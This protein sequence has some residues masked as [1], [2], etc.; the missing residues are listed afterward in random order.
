MAAHSL[1]PHYFL[2]GIIMPNDLFSTEAFEI[3]APVLD[4]V[5]NPQ[6]RGVTTDKGAGVIGV[7]HAKK[8]LGLLGGSDRVFR[9]SA[10]VYGESGQQGVFGHSTDSAGT[11]VYGNSVGS[12]WGVRG[13]STDGI[14]VQGQSFGNGLAGKF[15]GD[16]E[17]TGNLILQGLDLQSLI[18]QLRLVGNFAEQIQSLER[19]LQAL[20][21]E[22]QRLKQDI[23]AL[24]QSSSG[25]ANQLPAGS[26][27]PRISVAKS[28]GAFSIS[29]QGF[30]ANK[31]IS[32]RVVDDALA[33]RT[34]TQSSD[35]NGRFTLSQQIPCNAGLVLHFSA[36]DGR[37]NN[38]QEL[39]SNI[40]DT[41]C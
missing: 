5:K 37:L 3:E 29:G 19:R 25:S 20:A 12:G 36:T 16:V 13:D 28:S 41:T 7:S 6:L 17:I 33:S 21:Q 2:Q 30:L 24:K 34:F 22:N 4:A 23:E 11:G 38:G 35:A 27:S 31:S 8:S 1:S 10:G 32:V 26:A 18:Q 9:Q 39:W 15:I 40:V 14:A